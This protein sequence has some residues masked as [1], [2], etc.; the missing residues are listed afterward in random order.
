MAYFIITT[1]GGEFVTIVY[2]LSDA[3]TYERRGFQYKETDAY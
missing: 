2:R 3:V 1:Q